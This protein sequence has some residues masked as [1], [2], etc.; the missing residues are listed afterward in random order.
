MSDVRAERQ[1]W[2][3]LQAQWP[4]EGLFISGR[5]KCPGHPLHPW[6]S[7]KRSSIERHH[8][9]ANC[10]TDGAGSRPGGPGSRGAS[11]HGP[12]LVEHH[13]AALTLPAKGKPFLKL[14]MLAY[15]VHK[16]GFWRGAGMALA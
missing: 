8:L 1:A 15:A 6:A 3:E 13:A 5:P 7:L 12:A 16:Q 9:P 14:K 2:R 11:Q 10:V 4:A